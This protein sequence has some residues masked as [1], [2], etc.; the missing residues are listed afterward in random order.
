[1]LRR[2]KRIAKKTLAVQLL[3]PLAVGNITLS[4][5]DVFNVSAVYKA[6]FYI[7]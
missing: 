6:D 4:A 3:N 1:M 2:N 7:G 5:W